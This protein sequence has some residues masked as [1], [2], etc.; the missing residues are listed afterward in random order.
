MAQRKSQRTRKVPFL[1]APYYPKCLKYVVNF[2]TFKLNAQLYV[3]FILFMKI[4]IKNLTVC[5]CRK[6][7]FASDAVINNLV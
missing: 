6:F 5:S 4:T 3:T 2:L 7:H 1:I